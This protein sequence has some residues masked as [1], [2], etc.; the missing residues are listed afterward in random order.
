MQIEA[1]STSK[2]IRRRGRSKVPPGKLVILDVE[3]TGEPCEP[4]SVLGPYKTVIG[5]HVRDVIPIKYRT[6][7]GKAEDPWKVPAEEK[8]KVWTKVLASFDFREGIDMDL[9]RRRAFSTMATC[10][11]NFK[12]ELAKHVEKGTEPDWKNEFF[13][14]QQHWAEFRNY[15]VSEE[16]KEKSRKNKEN[17]AKNV[18]PHR[19]GSRGYLKKILE[20]DRQEREL[21]ARGVNPQTATWD[22]RSTRYLLGRGAS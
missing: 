16:A 3:P 11:S 2:P 21:V 8:E 17:S 9:V 14:Q 6:W 12:T 19:L 7:T 15:R 13:N 5:Y 1:P 10:F 18:H 4:P 22:L 20:W